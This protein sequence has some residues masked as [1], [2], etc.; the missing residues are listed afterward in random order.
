MN[1]E[2]TLQSDIEVFSVPDGV[3]TLLTKKTKVVANIE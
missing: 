1:K 3:K 2:F